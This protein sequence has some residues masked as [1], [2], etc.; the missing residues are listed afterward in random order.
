MREKPVPAFPTKTSALA[1]RE[2]Q[3]CD[4]LTIWPETYNGVKV[5]CVKRETF[6]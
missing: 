4:G 5:K 3:G 6:D 2:M 1:L